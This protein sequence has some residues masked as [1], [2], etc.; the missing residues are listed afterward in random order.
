MSHELY[1]KHRPRDFDGIV[2]QPEAVK[3]LSRFVKDGKVPHAILLTGA[4]GVG[5]TTM[6]RVL[7]R[8]L[9]I[10][11]GDYIEVNAAQTR[12]IDSVRE[13]QNQASRAWGRKRLFVLDE[14][15]KLTGDAQTALLKTL[16]DGPPH[17]YFVLCTTDPHKLLTTIKTRCTE[18]KLQ[19][20]SEKDLAILVAQ[21]A[22]KEGIALNS[23]ALDKIAEVAD[24]S[25]RK[26][27][28]ILGQVI[29]LDPEER[30]EAIQKADT[31]RQAI[32]LARILIDRDGNWSKCGAILKDLEDEPE[33]VRRLV[34]GYAA[35]VVIGGGP[36]A[37]RG[38]LVLDVF[39]GNFYDSGKPGLVWACYET[40]NGN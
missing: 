38:F 4:S 19:S 33:S 5:K 30:M 37:K 25:A 20:V 1:R 17:A 6:A 31:K 36:R 29:G 16:E 11:K 12:G 40:F 28:V 13:I 7:K 9:E 2:G 3:V 39:K 34:L 24:G 26:A 10:G 27:L 15:H 14:V 21:V 35:A 18:I 32:E 22:D 23:D 8:R